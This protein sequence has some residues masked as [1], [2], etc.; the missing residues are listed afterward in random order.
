MI[1]AQAEVEKRRH[2]D[3]KKRLRRR[4]RNNEQWAEA[5][6]PISGRVRSIVYADER[7]HVS[8]DE[9]DGSGLHPRPFHVPVAG[10]QVVKRECESIVGELM[11][12]V[13]LELGSGAIAY[14]VECDVPLGHGQR[15]LAQM[16][17]VAIGTRC[18]V[19][20]DASKYEVVF[21][22]DREAQNESLVG[23]RVRAGETKLMTLFY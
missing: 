18:V 10:S 5:L 7:Y 21:R 4:F 22:C 17:Q 15:P 6:S 1:E 8:I 2:T 3:G 16:D 23:K 11:D 20:F 19:S 12:H 13:R 9:E 14:T